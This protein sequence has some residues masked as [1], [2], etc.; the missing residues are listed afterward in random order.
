MMKVAATALL[1]GLLTAFTMRAVAVDCATSKCYIDAYNSVDIESS[2]ALGRVKEIHRRLTRTIGSQQAIRSKLLVIESDGYPWAVALQDN[3]IVI[4]TGAITD[5]YADGNMEMGDARTAFVVG[6]EL[7]HLTT[8]DLFHHKSFL[9]N[10]K[11]QTNK[12]VW[13]KSRPDEELR[14]DLRGYTYATIAGYKTDLLLGG[15]ENDF[16]RKWLSQI[17]SSITITGGGTHPDNETRREYVLAGFNKILADLPYYQFSTALAHFGHY[18]DAQLLLE[19]HLN[20]A[21]TEQAYSNLGY[22]HVQ[23]ARSYMSE[24]LAYKYWIP[25][26]LEPKSGVVPRGERSIFYNGMSKQ[27]LHHLEAAEQSLKQSIDMDDKNLASFINLAAVYLYMPDRLHRAYAA[28]EDAKRTPLGKLPAVQSQLE[29]IY[30]LIRVHDDADGGDRW[31]KAR[32]S[33]MRVAHTESPPP[34][35]LLFNLGRMLDNRGRDD[36]AQQYWQML[37]ERLNN[38]PV[39]YQKQVCRRLKKECDERID[40]SPWSGIGIPL[41]KDVRY[42]EIKQYLSENWNS[43]QTT[44]K[45]LPGLNAKVFTSQSGDSLLALDNHLEMV[46]LRNIPDRYRDVADLVQQHGEPQVYL[47]I[48]DGQLLSYGSWSA[49]VK[50]REV[51]EIWLDKLN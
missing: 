35:N 28:I 30:Q 50:E 24:E 39:A 38:L 21:E 51:V 46:I 18:K 5:M 49:V 45:N 1:G 22:I 15:G 31:P 33:L 37:H 11:H 43:G 26:L 2:P 12:P 40:N 9:Y 32:D 48:S 19:D 4:T 25:T 17:N 47:P 34:D 10:Q 13:L 29:S 3:T 27:A 7:S 20:I 36:T 41:G 8:E 44:P 23:R 16:F 6:H 42:P 14:A